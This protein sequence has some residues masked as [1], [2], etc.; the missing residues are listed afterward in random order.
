MLISRYVGEIIL[1]YW[2]TSESSP[3]V[4]LLLLLLLLLSL[5]YRKIMLASSSVFD[6]LESFRGKS[7]F[8][9]TL[10]STAYALLRNTPYLGGVVRYY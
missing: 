1:S 9:A 6:R 5:N 10:R 3:V 2:C 4:S 7:V 8:G